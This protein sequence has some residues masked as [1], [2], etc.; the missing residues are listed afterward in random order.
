MWVRV[1]E[2][3]EEPTFKIRFDIL[4]D[5]DGGWGWAVGWTFSSLK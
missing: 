3:I 4:Y 2:S 1:R 5:L